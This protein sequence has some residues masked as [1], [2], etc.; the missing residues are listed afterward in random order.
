[1]GGIL[2]LHG[3]HARNLAKAGRVESTA[4][5]IAVST[6]FVDEP[7]PAGPRRTVRFY[8]EPTPVKPKN[9]QLAATDETKW[10]LWTGSV[11]KYFES[12]YP[13]TWCEN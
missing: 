1:M 11:T 9:I 13:K 6:T 7:M 2:N 4:D 10:T 12:K 5:E 3:W 8:L